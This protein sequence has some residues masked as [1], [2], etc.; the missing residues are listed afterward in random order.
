VFV[1]GRRTWE[2]VVCA[3]ELQFDVHDMLPVR[4][5]RSA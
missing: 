5:V 3:S 4:V 1:C 2:W